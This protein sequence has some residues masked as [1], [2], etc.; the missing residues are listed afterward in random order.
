MVRAA[1][2]RAVMM[3]RSHETVPVYDC[4]NDLL[5]QAYLQELPPDG[6]L[7]STILAM[8]N[9]VAECSLN[10]SADFDIIR[11]IEC[12]GFVFKLAHVMKEYVATRGKDELGTTTASN[13]FTPGTFETLTVQS[14]KILARALMWAIKYPKT[15]LCFNADGT[16]ETNESL[17][18]FCRAWKPGLT[19]ADLYSFINRFVA[20]SL[21]QTDIATPASRSGHRAHATCPVEQDLASKLHDVDVKMLVDEY[22]NA[23]SRGVDYGDYCGIILGFHGN[24]KTSAAM[25][26]DMGKADV[27]SAPEDVASGDKE[28]LEVDDEI[29]L[30]MQTAIAVNKRTSKPVHVDEGGTA[31]TV[32]E[33]DTVVEVDDESDEDDAGDDHA[34]DAD[35]GDS[36]E[37]EDDDEGARAPAHRARRGGAGRAVDGSVVV[38]GGGGAGRAVDDVV[39]RAVDGPVVVV[40]GGPVEG[41]GGAGRA[42]VVGADGGGAGGGLA[43]SAV[44]AVPCPKYEP[45]RSGAPGMRLERNSYSEAMDYFNGNLASMMPS[46]PEVHEWLG[47]I[48]IFND[49]KRLKLRPAFSPTKPLPEYLRDVG[50]LMASA[51]A[52][53]HVLDINPRLSLPLPFVQHV[54]RMVDFSQSS[55]CMSDAATKA[56][57]E[58][59]KKPFMVMLLVFQ[60]DFFM[61]NR[62]GDS[63]RIHSNHAHPTHEI[64]TLRHAAKGGS[65]LMDG[66]APFAKSASRAGHIQAGSAASPPKHGGKQ[67]CI[68]DIYVTKTADGYAVGRVESIA[69]RNPAFE[70][71]LSISSNAPNVHLLMRQFT[72]VQARDRPPTNVTDLLVGVSRRGRTVWVKPENI[73]CPAVLVNTTPPNPSCVSF[74]PIVSRVDVQVDKDMRKTLSA[75]PLATAP[76]KCKVGTAP[77]TACPC[78]RGQWAFSSLIDPT[79]AKGKFYKR[80]YMLCIKHFGLPPYQKCGITLEEHVTAELK[81]LQRKLAPGFCFDIPANKCIKCRSLVDPTIT[82]N[83]ILGLP[84][85][86][87]NAR[88]GQQPLA[89]SFLPMQHTTFKQIPQHSIFSSQTPHTVHTTTAVNAPTIPA[90]ITLEDSPAKRSRKTRGGLSSTPVIGSQSPKRKGGQPANTP[91]RT[92][93]NTPPSAIRTSPVARQPQSGR[94][95][96]TRKPSK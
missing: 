19:T 14:Q 12:A 23:F 9:L 64:N 83:Q 24:E 41:G 11:R 76:L 46:E 55:H 88:K 47:G 91:K 31:P 61:D 38:V 60:S 73:V 68:E 43:G 27:S 58:N 52:I 85:L 39:G 50:R 42:V 74:C 25:Q 48:E 5:Q 28:V 96:Y 53:T 37:H 35:A 80:D 72:R 17:Y 16:Q 92:K 86:P 75:T 13:F 94:V 51:Q 6:F 26:D 20:L 56:A 29:D 87:V 89:M 33:D 67:I 63:K 4:I 45:R 65:N 8:Q 7:T 90:A 32:A 71:H 84:D 70:V 79:K 93:P 10:A 21:E 77:K 3:L 82:T 49:A 54:L 66:T 2:G 22:L 15:P 36:D 81:A 78:S 62:V 59:L 95:H 1:V 30:G 44:G 57:W 69:Q 40:G 18:Q 34:G